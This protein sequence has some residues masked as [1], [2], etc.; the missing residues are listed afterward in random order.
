MCEFTS[1]NQEN[2]LSTL[3]SIALFSPSDAARVAARDAA[4]KCVP[5]PFSKR[6]HSRSV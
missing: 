6:Q 2:E 5:Y 1:L 4:G 3:I